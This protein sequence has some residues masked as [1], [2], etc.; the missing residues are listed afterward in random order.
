M[1]SNF[2]RVWPAA[3]TSSDEHFQS[4]RAIFAHFYRVS[5]FLCLFS[6]LFYRM[7]TSGIFPA[8][9]NWAPTC[10]LSL[11]PCTHSRT[12]NWNLLSLFISAL[13]EHGFL[14]ASA[15]FLILY[16]ISYYSPDVSCT[17]RDCLLGQKLFNIAMRWLSET[18]TLSI[19]TSALKLPSAGSK[20]RAAPFARHLWRG[21]Q[22]TPKSQ[23]VMSF[24]LDQ[25]RDQKLR[26]IPCWRFWPLDLENIN[27]ISTAALRRL[28][29]LP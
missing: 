16:L 1:N 15:H 9:G 19:K 13:R 14:C 25:N 6:F 18:D 20:Q 23:T 3:R 7:V 29:R 8:G 17:R 28:I 12:N 10:L 27:E 11:C 26:G 21:V 24:G 2:A 4:P 22:R 5:H